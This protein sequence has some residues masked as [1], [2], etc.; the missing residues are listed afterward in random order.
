[1]AT[2]PVLVQK[3]VAR[4]GALSEEA[5]S[6]VTSTPNR[7]GVVSCLDP[8]QPGRHQTNG[9][10]ALEGGV[11][12]YNGGYAGA[13]TRHPSAAALR[14]A[15][16]VDGELGHGFRVSLVAEQATRSCATDYVVGLTD[17]AGDYAQVAL[18][19]LRT[20]LNVN[21]F[22]PGYFAV[23]WLP[24]GTEVAGAEEGNTAAVAVLAVSPKGLVDHWSSR[25]P[26]A[27]TPGPD[28]R[29]PCTPQRR[30]RTT[31][32]LASPPP[33]DR[34]QAHW[35]WRQLLDLDS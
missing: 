6:Q 10:L 30:H 28:G 24:G 7:A 8:D 18:F 32:P 9:W 12:D 33:N 31:N 21:S 22:P 17:R 2:L 14:Y 27:R 25:L 35:S 11:L 15:Q 23:R 29:R 1:M 13:E 5:S 20:A 4:P 34:L 16:R 3:Q 26:K 19:Q